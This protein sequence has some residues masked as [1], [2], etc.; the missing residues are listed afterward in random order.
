MREAAYNMLQPIIDLKFR[1]MQDVLIGQ[2]K[3]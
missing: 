3:Q 2:S 1:N